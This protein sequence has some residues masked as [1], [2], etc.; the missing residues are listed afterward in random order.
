M[1]GILE[2]ARA[3]CGGAPE[4]RREES[5]RVRSRLC[6]CGVLQ[7]EGPAQGGCG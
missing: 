3:L 2:V 4:L 1:G 5:E 7:A 6:G